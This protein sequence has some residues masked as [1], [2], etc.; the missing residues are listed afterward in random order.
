MDA[1]RTHG[2]RIV[3]MDL[4][5]SEL[6]EC[7][8]IFA[9]QSLT[10]VY[11]RTEQYDGEPAALVDVVE[12]MVDDTTFPESWLPPSDADGA[13][14][15]VSCRRPPPPCGGGAARIER[16]RLDVAFDRIGHEGSKTFRRRL[17]AAYDRTNERVA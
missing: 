11:I 1:P 13:A 5:E 4:S 17:A 10:E 9:D 8:S 7:R 15:A 14:G 16:R 6:R 2:R 3:K 12:M